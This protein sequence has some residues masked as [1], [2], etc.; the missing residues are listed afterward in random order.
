SRPFD[1]QR[2]TPANAPWRGRNVRPAHCGT[3]A[4]PG[5]RE[6]ARRAGEVACRRGPHVRGTIE[7][8]PTP[9]QHKTA[10]VRHAPNAANI[11]RVSALTA[12]NMPGIDAMVSI[13]AH[14]PEDAMS[15][16]LLGTERP[17][18][19]V[20]IREDGLIATI[21]YVVHEAEQIW[22]GSRSTVV[23]GVVV[24]YDFDSG[25][26]LVKPTLPL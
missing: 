1:Y 24:G 21:G 9:R 14:I 20:R 12:E 23:P 2:G 6:P 16:G 26:A 10:K 5:G 3:S 7:V 17:G 22:I 25:F 4:I 13:T 19:G 18:H 8:Q 15:A 11:A